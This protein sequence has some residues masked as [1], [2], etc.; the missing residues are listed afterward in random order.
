MITVEKWQRNLEHYEDNFS[1]NH[2][3]I[4]F[5]FQ[6]KNITLTPISYRKSTN[7]DERFIERA[8]TRDACRFR[9]VVSEC[10]ALPAGPSP[11]GTLIGKRQWA[12]RLNL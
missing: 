5:L 7:F 10:P 9:E 4:D 6:W 3:K 1:L 12:T 8:G 2:N 11:Q